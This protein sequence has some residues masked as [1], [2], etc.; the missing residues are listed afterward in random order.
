[1]ASARRRRLTE[2][3][4][5]DGEHAQEIRALCGIG[6]EEEDCYDRQLREAEARRRAS[7]WGDAEIEAQEAEAR[8]CRPSANCA[9][10]SPR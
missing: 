3:R 8:R 9:P 6:P 4:T 7:R 2:A 1:M 10:S 5:V